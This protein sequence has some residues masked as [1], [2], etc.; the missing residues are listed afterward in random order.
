VPTPKPLSSRI[1]AF[2]IEKRGIYAS[3]RMWR[4]WRV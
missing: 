1:A 3:R 4:V 2:S